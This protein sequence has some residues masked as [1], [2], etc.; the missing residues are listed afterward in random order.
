MAMENAVAMPICVSVI[1]NIE[2]KLGKKAIGAKNLKKLMEL[3]R[4][5]SEIANVYHDHRQP[6]VGLECS[7]HTKRVFTSMRCSNNPWRMNTAMQNL[8]AISAVFYFQNNR[9]VGLLRR[10]WTI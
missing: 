3:S 10:N 6:Y 5:V 4:F 1:P 9:A 2:F 8:W 7:L